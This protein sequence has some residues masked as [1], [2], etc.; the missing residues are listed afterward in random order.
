MPDVSQ[1]NVIQTND[2]RT[3]EA[4][5][6]QQQEIQKIQR[7]R[8]EEQRAGL[9]ANEA[10]YFRSKGI[11]PQQYQSMR[12]RGYS[13]ESIIYLAERGKVNAP[14]SP[15]QIITLNNIVSGKRV[16]FTAT[17]STETAYTSY[18]ADG[19]KSKEIWGMAQVFP[20]A[21]FGKFQQIIFENGKM[22]QIGPAEGINLY[23]APSTSVEY[24]GKYQSPTAVSQ[25]IAQK[26]ISGLLSG[27][28]KPSDVKLSAYSPEF[29]KRVEEMGKTGDW[30]AEFKNGQ[31]IFSPKDTNVV[32]VSVEPQKEP[33]ATLASG[34]SVPFHM[35]T[36]KQQAQV[37][38]QYP[39]LENQ[40]NSQMSNY[41]AVSGNYFTFKN[42]ILEPT[43]L[44]EKLEATPQNYGLAWTTTFN[45]KGGM[46]LTPKAYISQKYG[47]LIS[48]LMLSGL[49]NRPLE[50]GESRIQMYHPTHEDMVN[51]AI[52]EGVRETGETGLLANVAR[53]EMKLGIMADEVKGKEN[54]SVLMVG[55]Q[56][57]STALTVLQGALSAGR[58]M[59]GIRPAFSAYE[60]TGGESRA[61]LILATQFAALGV[62]SGGLGTL[63]VANGEIGSVALG[64]PI[65]EGMGNA[66][67]G[68]FAV[69]PSIR[70]EEISSKTIGEGLLGAVF[71]PK[72]FEIAPKF[73][74]KISEKY[75]A[76]KAFSISSKPEEAL[77][78]VAPDI[79]EIVKIGEMKEGAV[80]AYRQGAVVANGMISV[81]I[82]GRE[83]NTPLKTQ[84]ILMPKSFM[85]NLEEMKVQGNLPAT[86]EQL[87]RGAGK[88]ETGIRNDII[89]SGVLSYSK[90][91]YFELP[92]PST[93]AVVQ[94]GEFRGSF[95]EPQG[96]RIMSTN[97]VPMN[98]Y[99]VFST[100]TRDGSLS[101]Y[102]GLTEIS[103][104]SRTYQSRMLGLLNEGKAK[105]ELE[106]STKEGE[107]SITELEG[108]AQGFILRSENLNLLGAREEMPPKSF[109]QTSNELMKVDLNDLYRTY[110]LMKSSR[111]LGE[112]IDVGNFRFNKD[113][114]ADTFESYS[115]AF[116]RAELINPLTQERYTPYIRE[117]SALEGRGLVLKE[118]LN[119][120]GLTGYKELVFYVKGKA[121]AGDMGEIFK[122]TAAWVR[123]VG[124]LD[125]FRQG[126]L[127]GTP[128]YGRIEAKAKLLELGEFENLPNSLF[129]GDDFKGG[130]IFKSGLKL[131]KFKLFKPEGGE[132]RGGYTETEINVGNIKMK[133][134]MK[135]ETRS[136]QQ[137]EQ[138]TETEKP[139]AEA[140]EKR[141]S[142]KSTK[143]FE[144]Y[145]EK[146]AYQTDF[147]P[148]L[149]AKKIKFELGEKP[150]FAAIQAA[151]PSVKIEN[152]K[153]TETGYKL[154]MELAT[155]A[156]EK[157][158]T[159]MRS[160]FR[161]Q[162]SKQATSENIMLLS[163]P[164]KT[165]FNT[166]TDVRLK[167]GT[168]TLADTE[169][170]TNTKLMS[171][172][173]EIAP[174]SALKN[175]GN[176]VPPWLY[177]SK[178]K[179]L[180][181]GKKRSLFKRKKIKLKFGK[182][183][184]WAN[185]AN[186][187]QSIA[188]Y[189]TATHP[190]TKAAL[191][192]W[193]YSIRSEKNVKTIEQRLKKGKGNNRI[194]R[195]LL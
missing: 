22:K 20:E 65:R 164:T 92:K 137:Q 123:S 175:G 53:M 1:Y 146:T 142:K 94:Y 27:E 56:G 19:L 5:K 121:T 150:K 126:K 80:L 135:T 62:A 130:I 52:E 157:E 161:M 177:E 193:G 129:G 104:G 188:K 68:Y 58:T 144:K 185:L 173:P 88:S 140:E 101:L 158:K 149:E 44:A 181:E 26:N 95:S 37:A 90:N 14:L 23:T 63:A 43:G 124:F 8:E 12:E 24:R 17:E 143:E 148:L 133:M 79:S 184:I 16:E 4:Y 194:K 36:Q 13:K 178:K 87:M 155:K 189:G 85:T 7:A 166:Q 113:F 122:S 119:N 9:N 10:A 57:I 38:A 190:S 76:T 169:T 179:I 89:E 147:K 46:T 134:K 170:R 73:I 127:E 131:G 106:I 78:R 49:M 15:A 176:W 191:R 31:L 125:E 21:K 109:E 145:E 163:Q 165:A 154:K 153:Q 99:S 35:L 160:I 54:N 182:S 91:V 174:P 187:N 195:G 111:R 136:E 171:P 159:A 110:E 60:K 103:E 83:F 30:T 180:D 162:Q 172:S 183:S 98:F 117:A 128:E 151:K 64:T 107:F 42:N 167:L 138:K 141:E 67:R 156:Q 47:T 29:I 6:Q 72:M 50:Q 70:E 120:Y 74:P 66:L 102:R 45:E 115:G 39:Q 192:V 84:T 61:P 93:K 105:G 71:I 86:F 33:V 55:R 18:H 108:K 34:K 25:D 40:I 51:A 2:T 168:F 48:K 59:F 82:F 28:L 75:E 116:R 118:S 69:S 132:F 81:S 114:V 97:Q 152:A 186:V 3:Y 139:L 41:Y 112:R 100:L 96:I 32:S 77:G 11:S